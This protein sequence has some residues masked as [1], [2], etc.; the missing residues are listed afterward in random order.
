MLKAEP[1]G[2]SVLRSLSASRSRVA[3]GILF[4]GFGIVLAASSGFAYYPDQD[5]DGDDGND[6]QDKQRYYG[7]GQGS[8]FP[9]GHRGR[10][11]CS[12]RTVSILL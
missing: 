9:G 12:T 3:A 1:V 2:R 8:S 5:G 10:R 7:Y 6:Y 11:V 4:R